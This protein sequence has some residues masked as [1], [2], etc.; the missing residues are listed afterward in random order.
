MEIIIHIITGLHGSGKSEVARIIHEQTNAFI[1]NT[2][3][4]RKKMFPCETRSS[5]SDFTQNELDL[6]YRCLPVLLYYLTKTLHKNKNIFVFEGTFR[7]ESQR[8]KIINQALD[9]GFRFYL[10][11]IKTTNI[12][13]LKK[14]IKFRHEHKNHHATFETYLKAL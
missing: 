12:E 14:C 1:I 2:D 6:V 8:Q 13:F 10:W 7:L 5:D 4:V 11:Y 3:E 9:S